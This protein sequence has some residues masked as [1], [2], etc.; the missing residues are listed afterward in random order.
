[1][2]KKNPLPTQNL[3]LRKWGKQI[4]QNDF[5]TLMA[6]MHKNYLRSLKIPQ[7]FS[8]QQQETLNP[9]WIFSN[10]GQK[11]TSLQKCHETDKKNAL[12][13]SEM[14]MGS[15]IRISFY[16]SGYNIDKPL[17]LFSFSEYFCHLN[18]TFPSFVALFSLWSRWTY[19]E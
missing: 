16:H 9:F 3:P 13:H 6:M 17:T 12:C 10:C 18:V 2:F 15:I 11:I 19:Q 5:F 7:S 8:L 14:E 4:F 1:M